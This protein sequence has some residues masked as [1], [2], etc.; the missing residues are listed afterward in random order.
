MSRRWDAHLKEQTQALDRDPRRV[1]RA[2]CDAASRI[3]GATIGALRTPSGTGVANETVIFDVDAHEGRARRRRGL[4]R[5]ARDPGFALSRLRPVRPLPDVRDDDGV[6]V[7]PDTR[8]ARATKPMPGVVGAPFFVMERIDGVVPTDQ[9]SWATEGFVVDAEPAQRRAL[10]ERTV[11]TMA[12]LHRLDVRAVPV[13]ANGR[14][15]KRRR[16]LSRLLDAVVAMGVAGRTAA[17]HA[18]VRGVAA[19]QLAATSPRCRGAT[20]DCRT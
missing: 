11:R 7:G 9:P 2:G 20:A 13:P 8:R 17:A 10:W 18:G 19:R 3:P 16:R 15:R 14:D 5:S 12:E 4:R 6:P 1:S